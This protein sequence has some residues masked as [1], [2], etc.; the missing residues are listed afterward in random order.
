MTHFKYTFILPEV[1]YPFNLKESHLAFLPEADSDERLGVVL[2]AHWSSRTPWYS[3]KS[4][5]RKRA[6]PS[7]KSK[8]WWCFAFVNI[9]AP[10]RG[11][12][13][14]I[15][16]KNW[17]N[18]WTC[19][20]GWVSNIRADWDSTV[21]FTSDKRLVINTL[22]AQAQCFGSTNGL[23]VEIQWVLVDFSGLGGTG[24]NKLFCTP[25][26]GGGQGLTQLKSRNAAFRLKTVQRFLY[27]THT[28]TL[29]HRL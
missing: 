5:I 7:C 18:V 22:V 9:Y 6:P 28:H 3:V 23:L 13:R 25:V 21:D 8:N 19:E 20:C 10:N 4:R 24:W 14:I 29:T 15:I 2:W 12:D 26:H 16:F 17:V 1:K 11:A 27:L